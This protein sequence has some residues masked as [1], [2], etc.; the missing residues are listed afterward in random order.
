MKSSEKKFFTSTPEKK[1]LSPRYTEEE[2]VSLFDGFFCALMTGFGETYFIAFSV[3]SGLTAP[4]AALLGAWPL[5]LG[6]FMQLISPWG[7]RFFKSYKKWV[8]VAAFMQALSFIPLI[9]AAFTIHPKSTLD[10]QTGLFVFFLL[11]LGFYWA[12]GFATGPAWTLW[13]KSLTRAEHRTEFFSH[14]LKLSQIGIM[15]GIIL[16]GLALEACPDEQ[17]LHCFAGVFFSAAVFRLL[18]VAFLNRHKKQNPGCQIVMQ[19]GLRQSWLSF[20]KDQKYRSLMMFL[21]VFN[22]AIFFSAPMVTPFLLDFRKL[23]YLDFMFSISSFLFGKIVFLHY[24]GEWIK[25]WGLRRIFIIGALGISPLPALWP[26][27]HSTLFICLLQF[28]SGGMWSLFEVCLTLIFFDQI[29]EEE[30]VPVLS[31][32]NF[33]NTFALVLGASLGAL[34]MQNNLG[35]HRLS[36]LAYQNIFYLGS[37]LR[38]LSAFLLLPIAPPSLLNRVPFVFKLASTTVGVTAS[39]RHFLFNETLN[40]HNSKDK[41]Q[42]D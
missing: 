26:E 41:R 42:K 39:F 8:V 36:E 17:K 25:Q 40:V 37:A 1:W 29:K 21:F 19:K 12:S 28:A 23:S 34:F 5:L 14:R 9:V 6:A 7:V 13:I 35:S 22:S 16:G 20:F 38:L 15:I 31:L 24:A 10:N 4:L 32:F 30:K 18:S 2:R 27:A 11:A 3:Q 33:Y